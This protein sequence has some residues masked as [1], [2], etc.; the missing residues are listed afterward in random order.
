V[1]TPFY[2]YSRAALEQRFQEFDKALAGNPHV[3][4]F[5]M[6]ANANLAVLATFARLGG[7]FDIVTG[8]ELFRALKAGAAPSKIVF[9]GVGKSDEEIRYALTTG[10]LMF[11]AESAEEVVALDRVAG[12]MGVKA[13]ISIRVNPDVDPQTHPYISTGMKKSK[14]GVNISQARDVYKHALQCKNIDVVGVDCHIGSQLTKIE[15]FIDSLKKVLP[16]VDEL[17]AAG[18]KIKF[19]DFGGGLGI[20]YNQETPPAPSEYGGAVVDLVKGRDLTLICEPGR[21]LVGNA[22]ALV[23]KVIFN[24]AGEVK[25]FVIVD[26]GMNDLIRPAFYDAYHKIQP[27]VADPSRKEITVDVVGPICESGDF[28]A[29]DRLLPQVNTGELLAVMSAGAYGFV[30]SSN[31]NGRPRVP[32]ILVDGDRFD[33]VRARETLEDLIRG[34]HIPATLGVRT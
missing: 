32:E 15:P 16:M 20:T 11:N 14:F 3:I 19:L 10:I 30:M 18:A 8:G 28:L 25:H 29:H 2:V 4:C 1:G 21:N 26:A 5:A 12:S 23:T 17:R 9:S 27:V 33:T 13:P 22:G 6:K 34:E 24:K 7:G 31:Y